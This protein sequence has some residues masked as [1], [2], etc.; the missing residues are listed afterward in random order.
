MN[1]RQT[2]LQSIANYYYQKLK[3]DST[4]I[5]FV[6]PSRRA[7]IFFID[8]L[9][10]LSDQPIFAPKIITINDL[11]ARRSQ[12]IIADNITLLFRLHQI[13]SRITGD[14]RS[15]DEFLPWG[16]MILSD[17]EDI[18]K[19]MVDA[20]QLFRNL[21]DYKQLDDD[22]SHLSEAQRKAIASFWG[23]LHLQK[24]S[25]HQQ[26]FINTWE[27]LNEVYTTFRSEL[28][29]HN[30]AYSGMT[31][32]EVAEEIQNQ[33]LFDDH[34]I[35]YAFIGFNAL[36]TTEHILFKYLQKQNRAQFF[37]DYSEQI[38]P[39]GRN[40]LINRG[41]GMFLSEN[42]LQY[43]KPKDWEMPLDVEYPE[44]TITAV[45]H[46]MEQNAE[47]TQFLKDEYASD[48]RCAVILTDE[49]MLLP[50]L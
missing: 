25:E 2:F 48:E 15:F 39:V 47:I 41:A 49:N 20:P 21:I 32:R 11:F 28:K 44:I 26:S 37:W 43:P 13:Y 9:K 34:D 6:F 14:N 1:T 27:K 42:V 38:L 45:A 22:Y 18:D 30:I 31:Y 29:A 36:T 4:S 46:P 5:C 33:K 17:F 7:G 16:E 19:Y 40:G 35:K 24:L 23:T 12:L 3:T 50:V 8:C 10:Q